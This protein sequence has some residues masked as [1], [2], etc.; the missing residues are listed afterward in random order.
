MKIVRIKE[1]NAVLILLGISVMSLTTKWNITFLSLIWNI[2]TV[3]MFY[4]VDI[5]YEST[6]K[7]IVKSKVFSVRAVEAYR[8]F[9]RRGS[10]IF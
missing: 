5:N 7:L 10:H 1:E 6:R 3:K 2:F 4:T 8:I 9:K